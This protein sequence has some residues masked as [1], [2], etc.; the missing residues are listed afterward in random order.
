MWLMRACRYNE[1]YSMKTEDI[2]D[3]Y[4]EQTLC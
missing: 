2:E 3:Y 1:L 4:Y